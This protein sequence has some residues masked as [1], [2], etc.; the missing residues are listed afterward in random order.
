[1][2]FARLKIGIKAKPLGS[3]QV[4][5]VKFARLKIGIKA[6]LAWNGG[7]KFLSLLA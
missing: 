6:K 2:K 7:V 1:M 4:S 3:A 5:N